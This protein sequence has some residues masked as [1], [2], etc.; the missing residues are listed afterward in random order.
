M[1]TSGTLA[2]VSEVHVRS[3]LIGTLLL[4]GCTGII[5]KHVHAPDF[6][7]RA[8]RTTRQMVA[9]ADGTDLHTTVQLPRGEG[10]WPTIIYRTPYDMGPVMDLLCRF[11]NRYGYACTWQSVRGRNRSEGPWHPFEHER[12][13]T[14]AYLDWVREQPW[15]DGH[16][17]LVGESYLSAVHWIVADQLPPEVK[18]MVLGVFGMDIYD[19]LYADGLIRHE[20]A[21]AWATLTD[22]GLSRGK[23]SRLYRESLTLWPADERDALWSEEPLPWYRTWVHSPLPDDAFWRGPLPTVARA[24][25]GQVTVPVFLTGGWSDGFIGPQVSTWEGLATREDSLFVVSP[26]GHLGQVVGDLQM[27]HAEEG[28]GRYGGQQLGRVVGWLDHHLKGAPLELPTGV[29]QSYVGGADVWATYDAW[30]PPSQPQRWHLADPLPRCMGKARRAAGEGVATWTHD[31]ANPV[32]AR[33]GAGMIASSIPGFRTGVPVGPID[34][35]PVCDRGDVVG[36]HTGPFPQATHIAGEITAHLTVQSSEP[37]TAFV[38]SISEVR[39]DGRVVLIREAFTTLAFHGVKGGGD[40]VQIDLASWPVDWQVR[41][42]S[43]LRIELSSSRWPKVEVHPGGDGPIWAATELRKAEQTV[44]LDRS[45]VEL[46]VVEPV[47][48]AVA[49]SP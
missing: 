26:T 18:T 4:G 41:P 44:Y 24:V 23:A 2:R 3:I 9:V 11:W 47:A 20:N 6:T 25:P 43:Q 8:G 27:P 37:D 5:R 13:D 38:V 7:D 34:P 21:T 31:P 10:P 46:P 16:W 35:G 15:Q 32:P 42:G 45:W 1:W 36:F 22:P 29:M 33:G 48:E 40:P 28:P 39:P 19:A 17:A 12:A 14:M 30:P 49:T